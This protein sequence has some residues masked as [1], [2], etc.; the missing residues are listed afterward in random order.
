MTHSRL[1]HKQSGVAL[2]SV[3]LVV[4]IVIIIAADMNGRLQLQMQRQINLQ[5]HQQAYWYGMSAE[6]F[7][8]QVI[9]KTLE[10]SEGEVNLS[11]PWAAKDMAYP[12]D[13][14]TIAGE[15]TDLQACLNLNALK[16]K[17]ANSNTNTR[18]NTVNYATKSLQRLFELV[19]LPT[20]IYPEDLAMRVYDWLDDDSQL[21]TGG[22][23]EE[24]D[25]AALEHP[26]L[27][28]NTSMV[29]ESELRLIL[30]FN[31]ILIA[32]LKPYLCV[33]PNTDTQITNVNTLTEEQAPLLAALF[34]K[35]TV[36]EAQ[37][38]LSSRGEAGFGSIDDFWDHSDVKKQPNLDDK[39]KKRFDIKSE[40]FKLKAI[41]TYDQ[42]RF[43]LTSI[44]TVA[45]NK[46]NAYQV[47]TLARRFGD[48]E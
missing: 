44:L 7:V 41:T 45:D 18:T 35:M 32:K 16:E 33:I 40:F 5:G 12:V 29:T 26:Y 48:N 17:S 15:I 24:D 38:V 30:G 9:R 42:S 43:K 25:Y 46:Q 28:A 13:N 36:A 23:A 34:E 8:K 4:A 19:E 3:L 10:D 37:N 31:P 2:V 21:I 22:S 6:A 20:D 14:G 27:S 47:K 39:F 11:Q 1:A